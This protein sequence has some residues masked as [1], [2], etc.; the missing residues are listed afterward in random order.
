MAVIQKKKSRE[1][2]KGYHEN[3]TSLGN[4]RCGFGQC[5]RGVCVQFAAGVHQAAG[6]H[7]AAG[8]QA[9]GVQATDAYLSSAG[10]FVL[11]VGL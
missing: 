6:V 11:L 7:S 1:K 2:R 10:A 3:I 4:C 9:T 5:V 8:V